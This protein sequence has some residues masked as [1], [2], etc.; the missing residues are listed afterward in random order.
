[1]VETEGWGSKVREAGVPAWPSGEEQVPEDMGR[2][3]PLMEAGESESWG[4]PSE[5][6]VDLPQALV[7]AGAGERRIVQ[8]CGSQLRGCNRMMR[9][10]GGKQA[11]RRRNFSL[12]RA[13]P[14][15]HPA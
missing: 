14:L 11:S 10:R 1:M 7:C 13:L 9:G 6:K 2:G 5:M 8:V 12:D 15:P 4:C 3:S